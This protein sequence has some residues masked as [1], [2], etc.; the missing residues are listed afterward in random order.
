MSTGKLIDI[1]FSFAYTESSVEETE[2]VGGSIA[3]GLSRA[4]S[5]FKVPLKCRPQKDK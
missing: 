5:R 4:A 3:S 1:R 2:T